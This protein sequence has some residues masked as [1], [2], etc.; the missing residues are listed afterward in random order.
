MSGGAQRLDSINVFDDV[1]ELT[2]AKYSVTQAP[3]GTSCPRSTMGQQQARA[4]ISVGHHPAS[5]SVNSNCSRP[6]STAAHNVS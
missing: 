2:P 3:V 1:R 5:S 6:L 4:T